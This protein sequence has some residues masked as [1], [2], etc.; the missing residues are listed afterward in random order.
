MSIVYQRN[1]DCVAEECGLCVREMWIVCRSAVRKN[2]I[3]SFYDLTFS[4]NMTSGVPRI[5]LEG[6]RCSTYSVENRGQRNG[7]LVGVDP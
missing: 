4:I 5:F 6:G 1:V 3:K 7:D 2:Y